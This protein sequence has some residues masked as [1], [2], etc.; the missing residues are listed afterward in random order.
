M[1]I[2][3]D[4]APATAQESVAELPDVIED[5]DAEKEEMFGGETGAAL[6]VMVA[7][8]VTVPPA[9]VAVNV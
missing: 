8:W 1:S 4:V 7:L 9:P 6:T 3:I 2:E 5:G